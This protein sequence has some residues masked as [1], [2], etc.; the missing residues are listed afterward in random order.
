[1]N[2]RILP[3]DGDGRCHTCPKGNDTTGKGLGQTSSIT[4]FYSEVMSAS[5]TTPADYV[6]E[7]QGTATAITVNMVTFA[8]NTFTDDTIILN[9]NIAD[10]DQ[11]TGPWN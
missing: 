9:L 5:S 8:T 6:V 7:L 3:T 11:T 1:M 10:P 2:W 4:L